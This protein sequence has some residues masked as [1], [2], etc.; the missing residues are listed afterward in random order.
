MPITPAITIEELVEILPEAISY[1]SK[2]EVRCIRCGEP[3]WGTLEEA[4][5]QKGFGD[6]EIKQFVQDLNELYEK[7]N[8]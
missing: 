8:S 3:I 4:A 2:K 6:D 7:M 1:L 5:R